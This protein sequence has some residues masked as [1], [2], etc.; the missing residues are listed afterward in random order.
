[1]AR[2]AL[3]ERALRLYQQRTATRTSPCNS[4]P[5]ATGPPCLTRIQK[6]LTLYQHPCPITK[7]TRR[8]STPILCL[9]ALATVKSITTL[10]RGRAPYT[11][12]D[13]LR[14]LLVPRL[15]TQSS[16]SLTS[17]S[18]HFCNVRPLQLQPRQ[19]QPQHFSFD[20]AREGV[21]YSIWKIEV[22]DGLSRS[23]YECMRELLEEELNNLAT[24]DSVSKAAT[25]AQ[26]SG[27]LFDADSTNFPQPAFV[28]VVAMYEPVVEDD[29]LTD[30]NIFFSY[31]VGKVPTAAFLTLSQKDKRLLTLSRTIPVV[32]ALEVEHRA[33]H[34][35]TRWTSCRIVTLITKLETLPV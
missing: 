18:L 13:R 8:Y 4:S 20:L 12:P 15:P 23:Q 27:Q 26:H 31:P 24:A 11:P 16:S 10:S 2:K 5:I 9:R 28:N 22:A 21:E 6:S 32:G 17:R 14:A 34:P 19:H 30:C 35:L 25:P 1:V 33:R 7:M 29:T 3:L